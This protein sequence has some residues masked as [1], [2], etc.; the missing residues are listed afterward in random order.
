MTNLHDIQTRHITFSRYFML[1]F[2]SIV[3][4]IHV[5]IQ[6]DDSNDKVQIQREYMS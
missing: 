2:I 6:L 3:I 5:Y 1:D 4:H